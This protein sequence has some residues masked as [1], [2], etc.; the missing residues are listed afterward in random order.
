MVGPC[1]RKGRPATKILAPV[2][3]QASMNQQTKTDF[4]TTLFKFSGALWFP[5]RSTLASL[6]SL[7]E[8]KGR[9]TSITDTV[10][11]SLT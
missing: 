3:C 5:E 8:Q 10:R 2:S 6:C 11:C 1:P 9:M 4:P 7:K